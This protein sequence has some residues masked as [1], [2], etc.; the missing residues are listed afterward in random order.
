MKGANVSDTNPDP[1][2]GFLQAVVDSAYNPSS[3]RL[4]PEQSEP[5]NMTDDDRRRH[6]LRRM[7]HEALHP[8]KPEDTWQR[9]FATRSD[10]TAALFGGAENRR[11]EP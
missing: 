3:R 6:G 4:E 2:A 7:L 11:T 1:L 8:A 9:S 5:H 10:T